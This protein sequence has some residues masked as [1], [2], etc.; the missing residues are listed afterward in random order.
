MKCVFV[1]LHL[2]KCN[3]AACVC[4][5]RRA[6]LK[7]CL[8]QLKEQVPL[9]SESARNTT[10]SLLRQAQLH[11]KVSHLEHTTKILTV[12]IYRRKNKEI[13]RN[14]AVE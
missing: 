14:Q 9:S 6:Q 7:H 12:M 5:C 4:G 3:V 10:L 11:I 1:V 8:E 2:F 13:E